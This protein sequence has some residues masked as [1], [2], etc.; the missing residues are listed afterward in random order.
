MPSRHCITWN[1]ELKVTGDKRDINQ[2]RRVYAEL[3]D[4]LTS[5]ADSNPH[6][7]PLF[8]KASACNYFFSDLREAVAYIVAQLK[9]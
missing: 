3:P 6:I 1:D 4:G 8:P 5:L 9:T 2:F 7:G